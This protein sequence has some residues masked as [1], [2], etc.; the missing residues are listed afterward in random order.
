MASAQ[1]ALSS[2]PADV[3]SKH[4]AFGRMDQTVSQQHVEA[5]VAVAQAVAAAVTDSNAELGELLGSCA[6]SSG[7][8]ADTCVDDFIASFG[9]RALR[10]PLADAEKSFYRDTYAVSGRIDAAALADVVTVML[11][12]PQFVYQVVLGGAAV[13]GK[14][15]LYQLSE[16]EIAARLSYDFWQ[17]TP[18]DELLAA[19]DRGELSGDGGFQTALDHVLADP[20]AVGSVEHLARE[21]LGLDNLRDMDSLV[22]DPVFDA[23]AGADVPGPDLKEDMI[24]EL[25][26]S[27][28]F[29]FSGMDSLRDWVQSPYSF[30]RD[31]LL[32]RI[33]GTTP[34]DGQSEPPQFPDGER[35]GLITRAALLATGSANTRPIMKGVTIRERLLCDELPP[36]PANAAKNPP[37]LSPTLTTREVVEDLTQQPG[38]SC[39]GCHLAQINPLGFATESFDAL[40]RKRDK[41]RL[42]SP[43]GQLL[44]EKAVDT[45]TIPGVWLTDGTESKG[46]ADLTRLLVQSGKLEACFARQFVRFSQARAED[47]ALDGCALET[48]RDS[49]TNGESFKTALRKVAMLPAFRQRLLQSDG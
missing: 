11:S 39:S 26:D 27:M 7:S 44:T 16:Y 41:Q 46:P 28:G 5:Y 21:W 18:D 43:D 23:F 49:L 2:L 15:G 9:K 42:F 32:A 13:D 4:A 20:R 45:M 40:G 31:E 35:A 6:S 19:A 24:R 17:S 29:H 8:A 33:Y 36:P 37:S 3:V 48:L 47:A 14:A 30:A 1:S 38:S 22:G 12:G 10:R 34:W 25:T